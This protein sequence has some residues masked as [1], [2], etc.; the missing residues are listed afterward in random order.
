MTLIEFYFWFNSRLHQKTYEYSLNKNLSPVPTVN[1]DSL[2]IN[3]NSQKEPHYFDFNL[4]SW[5]WLALRPVCTTIFDIKEK[6]MAKK[7][8]GGKKC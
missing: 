2:S 4:K 3:T 1:R 6:I 7:K 8:G 5:S